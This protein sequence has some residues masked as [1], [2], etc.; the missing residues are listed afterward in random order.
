MTLVI[1]ADKDKMVVL[2]MRGLKESEAA[3]S[4]LYVE[5]EKERNMI[6]LTLFKLF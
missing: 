4:A 5:L 1:E 6:Y 3:Q 2:L